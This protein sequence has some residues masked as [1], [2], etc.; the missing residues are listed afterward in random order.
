MNKKIYLNKSYTL[1]LLKFLVST[2]AYAGIGSAEIAEKPQGSDLSR[3]FGNDE[4]V[5]NVPSQHLSAEKTV[6]QKT[7]QASNVSGKTLTNFTDF[8]YS[9][10]KPGFQVSDKEIY[11]QLIN[12]GWK[13]VPFN[14]KTGSASNQEESVGGVIGFRGKDVIIATRGTQIFADWLTN[15]RVNIGRS[16]DVLTDTIKNVAPVKA[17]FS[18]IFPSWYRSTLKD[19]DDMTTANY[20]PG[21]QGRAAVGFLQS[22]LSSWNQIKQEIMEYAKSENLKLADLHYEFTGHSMGAAKGQLNALGML[23]DQG[24]KIGVKKLEDSFVLSTSQL[25]VSFQAPAK[26]SDPKNTGNVD[27]TVFAS[28]RT[29]SK[30]MAKD[31]EEIIG[32]ENLVRIENK[33]NGL[34]QDPVTHVAPKILGFDH[35]GTSVPIDG[36]GHFF[37]RHFMGSIRDLASSAI[38]KFRN[39]RAQRVK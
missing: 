10:N 15:L 30:D 37:G 7:A 34:D 6:V 33:G 36:G 35:I 11:N 14:T 32:K 26:Y 20:F 28:P 16:F 17:V 23:T 18:K 27:V 25:G 19:R 29:F 24:L 5:E 38:D 12:D 2:S 4:E 9:V 3:R 22:H 13:L 31:A 8:A 39:F 1:I 21:V